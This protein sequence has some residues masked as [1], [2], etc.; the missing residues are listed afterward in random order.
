MRV[1]DP[2]PVI[3]L[4]SDL[5]PVVNATFAAVAKKISRINLDDPQPPG[6]QYRL[7]LGAEYDSWVGRRDLVVSVEAFEPW[8]GY[9]DSLL[10]NAVQQGISYYEN[11][12]WFHVGGS[13]Y[14]WCGDLLHEG[15]RVFRGGSWHS[16]S[17][18]VR[19]AYWCWDAPDYSGGDLSFRL[20]RGRL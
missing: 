4:R 10:I 12:L 2:Y 15:R 11:G 14:C 7:P 18:Y 16:F 17:R 1:A 9:V 6:Y 20:L 5:T 19:A 13:V 3:A 8:D